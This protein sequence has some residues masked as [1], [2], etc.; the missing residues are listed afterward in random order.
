MQH[1]KQQQN[2]YSCVVWL[3]SL[4]RSLPSILFRSSNPVFFFFSP[5]HQSN[6]QC[7]NQTQSM[8]IRSW[9]YIFLAPGKKFPLYYIHAVAEKNRYVIPTF[10]DYKRW[11]GDFLRIVYTS[12]FFSYNFGPYEYSCSFIALKTC[13]FWV[14][15]DK[16]LKPCWH[17]RK[18]A[19]FKLRFFTHMK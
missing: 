6:F 7:L 19:R 9:L 3:A 18:R 8:N 14:H 15:V 11:P 10:Q 5:T 13:P 4:V 17:E 16:S 12:P 1:S 2:S